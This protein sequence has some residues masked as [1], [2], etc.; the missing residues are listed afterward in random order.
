[1]ANLQ[2]QFF[3]RR[4]IEDLHKMLPTVVIKQVNS[5]RGSD[6]T[7]KRY[8][9]DEY[10]RQGVGNSLS[11]KR[12]FVYDLYLNLDD[13]ILA[14]TTFNE[15]RPLMNITKSC[16]VIVSSDAG[17]REFHNDVA[18]SERFKQI[19]KVMIPQLSLALPK[20]KKE[21]SRYD[22]KTT[23]FD[24]N[25]GIAEFKFIPA[26]DRINPHL[27]WKNILEEVLDYSLDYNKSYHSKLH[28]FNVV[29]SSNLQELFLEKAKNHSDKHIL[30]NFVNQY[31]LQ[32]GT[33]FQ[34]NRP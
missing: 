15:C 34:R 9:N 12:T 29:K 25:K 17:I 1:M 21:S 26:Y 27:M 2:I 4:S 33:S 16:Q 20:Y 18:N 14:S 24:F 19:M 31:N 22:L 3:S 23:S 8:M 13:E 28:L 7:I 5:F 10:S 11:L 6:E 32:N 30:T